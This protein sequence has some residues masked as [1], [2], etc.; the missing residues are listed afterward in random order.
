MENFSDMYKNWLNSNKLKSFL[1]NLEK[2]REDNMNRVLSE[3]TISDFKPKFNMND[4]QIEEIL[5]S[6][7]EFQ[8]LTP[9]EKEEV[10]FTTACINSGKTKKMLYFEFIKTLTNWHFYLKRSLLKEN[11]ELASKIRDV[12]NIDIKEFYMYMN[13]YRDDFESD[14]EKIIQLTIESV[15]KQFN[16]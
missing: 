7:L 16:I 10:E 15:K 11:Y 9:L 12:I 5:D 6:I 8:T 2:N 4:K 14:D 3:R 1:N 13:K